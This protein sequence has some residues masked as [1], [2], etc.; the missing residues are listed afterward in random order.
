MGTLKQE[1]VKVI[2]FHKTAKFDVSLFN[3]RNVMIVF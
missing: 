3:P 2:K 1:S